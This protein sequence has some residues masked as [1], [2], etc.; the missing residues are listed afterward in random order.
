MPV[1]SCE[2]NH[3]RLSKSQNTRFPY[4][5]IRQFLLFCPSARQP[6][7]LRAPPADGLNERLAFPRDEM[8]TPN[9][10]GRLIR[11]DNRRAVRSNDEIQFNIH[12]HGGEPGRAPAVARRAAVAARQRSAF[13]G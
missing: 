11:R 7:K 12:A 1:E 13:S 5:R 9:E 10:S 4:R 8:R 3:K 2:L 6:I